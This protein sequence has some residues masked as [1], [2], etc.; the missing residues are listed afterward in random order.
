M[1]FNPEPSV[2]QKSNGEYVEWS[3]ENHNEAVKILINNR[4]IIETYEGQ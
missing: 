3:Q 2:V 1:A 4:F